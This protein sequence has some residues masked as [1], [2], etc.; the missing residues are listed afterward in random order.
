MKLKIHAPKN[1]LS[2][3][4]DLPAS[5]SESNRMLII[6]ALSGDRFKINNLSNADDTRVLKQ[7]LKD[8]QN[9]ETTIDVGHA[10][11]SFRFLTAYLSTLSAKQ[12]ELMGSER[13]KERPCGELVSALRSMGAEIDFIENENFPPLKIKGS[14]LKS[15]VSVRGD[16]SSQFISALM[17]IAPC[18]N[19]G[20]VISITSEIVSEP[21]LRMTQ[22]LMEKCGSVINFSPSSIVIPPKRYV[23]TE[24]SIESDWS[25]AAFWF[26]MMAIRGGRLQLNGLKENSLQGDRVLV[27]VYERLGV[28]TTFN[29]KGVS[30]SK[31]PTCQ[32][33][34]HFEYDFTAFP[35]LAQAVASTCVALQIP[36][37]L[38][39]LSTLKIKETDRIEALKKEF[40]KF[41]VELQADDQSLWCQSIEMSAPRTSLNTHKDHR[42]AMC[43][44]PM[45]L[46][47]ENVCIE[48]PAVVSKSYPTF[49]KDLERVGFQLNACD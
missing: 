47:A 33:L 2:G 1:S 10:G 22:E 42:M 20:L 39:G 3:T 17:L 31:S 11:T 7:A 37:K 13:M 43:L 34:E 32:K 27:E 30:I 23:G 12:F 48:D 4:I 36:F 14:E 21:Y 8:I 5:K 9:G 40:F 28:L 38:K 24:Y 41:G 46:M 25:A 26:E 16:V 6:N 49:W 15:E 19:Q 29:S 44:A 35:D 45:S 18:L